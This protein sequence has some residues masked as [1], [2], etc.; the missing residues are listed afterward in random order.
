MKW[1]GSS[2][3]SNRVTLEYS[4]LPQPNVIDPV[5][6]PL[7]PQQPVSGASEP[8]QP[9]AHTT[10]LAKPSLNCD[11]LPS[12][13]APRKRASRSLRGRPQSPSARPTACRLLDSF[14]ITSVIYNILYFFP[15]GFLA[16]CYSNQL[17]LTCTVVFSSPLFLITLT[18]ACPT[19]ARLTAGAKQ[20]L[21]KHPSNISSLADIM[22]IT[23]Q[24]WLWAVT[25]F[26]LLVLLLVLNKITIMG[27]TAKI[28]EEQN[29]KCQAPGKQ[30]CKALYTRK[31]AHWKSHEQPVYKEKALVYLKR[32]KHWSGG[33]NCIFKYREKCWVTPAT[34]Q[35][36]DMSSLGCGKGVSHHIFFF[37][38]S[39]NRE[40]L[41]ITVSPWGPLDNF[42]F[43]YI[44]Y[45]VYIYNIY[46]TIYFKRRCW[47]R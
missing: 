43:P 21:H 34:A 23:P 47:E 32:V 14:K 19:H 31:G 44:L 15:L 36:Q 37:T 18:S 29:S 28:H 1:S 11:T 8:L 30:R 3:Y 16:F 40:V 24:G 25:S 38:L 45:I 33:L 5:G 9:L 4:D 41:R 42:G 2:L 10:P 6:P 39:R 17:E 12:P 46:D 35:R 26:Q 22:I 7:A 27:R 20:D 13:T